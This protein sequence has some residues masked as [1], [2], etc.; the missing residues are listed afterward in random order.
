MFMQRQLEIEGNGVNCF[1]CFDDSGKYVGSV[2]LPEKPSQAQP[3]KRT[4]FNYEYGTGRTGSVRVRE[5]W[6]YY[7][8]SH[9]SLSEDVG[10]LD[11]PIG[12]VPAGSHSVFASFGEEKI[13]VTCH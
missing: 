6:A 4:P 3:K 11:A 7:P 13:F 12:R 2:H 5:E 1:D 10:C 8:G 9:H